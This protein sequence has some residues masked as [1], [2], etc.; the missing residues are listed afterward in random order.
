MAANDEIVPIGHDTSEFAT[1]TGHVSP[2]ML[3][4]M[5][6]D[7]MSQLPTITSNIIPDLGYGLGTFTNDDWARLQ[8][9]VGATTSTIHLPHPTNLQRNPFC[10]LPSVASVYNGRPRIEKIDDVNWLDL[11]SPVKTSMDHIPWDQ[12]HTS[13]VGPTRG[14]VCKAVVS[15][16]SHVTGVTWYLKLRKWMKRSHPHEG[17]LL[18]GGHAVDEGLGPM[19]L[20]DNIYPSQDLPEHKTGTVNVFTCPIEV[21]VTPP[22]NR[23][24]Q[25]GLRNTAGGVAEML[26]TKQCPA[27]GD[28]FWSFDAEHQITV[29]KRGLA[30]KG[31]RNEQSPHTENGSAYS[32]RSRRR[33]P[34]K[35]VH[36]TAEPTCLRQDV[37]YRDVTRPT[38]FRRWARAMVRAKCGTPA[39][40]VANKLMVEKIVREV[41]TD[42]GVRPTQFELHVPVIVAMVF[43]ASDTDIESTL[44]LSSGEAK[45]RMAAFKSTTLWCRIWGVTPIK[46]TA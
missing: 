43:L 9:P 6:G 22:K 1:P 19:M 39:P 31:F 36:P 3:G 7:D 2:P 46:F 15:F 8:P 23:R 13:Y 40:T 21:P 17:R 29:T 27:Q 16:A 33:K 18:K 45:M 11:L 14:E 20:K 42:H 12:W 38:H 32:R 25:L 28:L 37:K 5:G 35:D 34:A 10:D 24:E 26:D 30:E 41:L 4:H 44:L